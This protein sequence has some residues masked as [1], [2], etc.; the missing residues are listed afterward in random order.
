MADFEITQGDLLPS[1][2]VQLKEDGVVLDLTNALSADIII[3]TD[4]G[5]GVAGTALLNTPA[6]IETPKTNGIVKYDWVS[7]QTNTPGSYLIQVEVMW[8]GPKPETAPTG[9]KWTM[10]IWPALEGAA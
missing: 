5:S 3:Y 2:R 4:L 7:P 1:F 6:V 9:A 10:V 8:P